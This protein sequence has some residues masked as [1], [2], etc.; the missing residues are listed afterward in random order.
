MNIVNNDMPVP[1][2][3][4]NEE[5]YYYDEEEEIYKLTPKATEK[6]KQSYIEYYSQKDD[7]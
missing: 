2:F 4:T 3:I 5:W 7:D 1:Y 6:A